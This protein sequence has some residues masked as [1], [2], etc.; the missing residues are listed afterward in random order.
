MGKFMLIKKKFNCTQMRNH[1][2]VFITNK[3][4]E[5]VEQCKYLCVILDEHLII[6]FH[7]DY[8]T[9]K[10]AKKIHV[11]R[12]ISGYLSRWSKITIYIQSCSLNLFS[13]SNTQMA[14]LQKKKNQVMQYI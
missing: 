11:L 14:P 6:P 4:I 13:L 9:N 10:I 12:R 8:F 7:A 2:G 1:F 5:R 3:R